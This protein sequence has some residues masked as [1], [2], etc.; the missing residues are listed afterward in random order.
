M[1][2]RLNIRR[3]QMPE[4]DKESATF[5]VDK[6][7][8]EQDWNH[9]VQKLTQARRRD[10]ERSFPYLFAEMKIIRPTD[11][12]HLQPRD[13]EWLETQAKQN[14][15]KNWE[16]YLQCAYAL[17]LLNP[18]KRLNLPRN[19]IPDFLYF[20]TDENMGDENLEIVHNTFRAKIAHPELEYI[21]LD[22]LLPD[23]KKELAA[24]F[25]DAGEDE[26]RSAARSAAEIR[27]LYPEAYPTV[28]EAR[29][30]DLRAALALYKSSDMYRHELTELAAAMTI[31]AA[32]DAR[33]TDQG[34]YILRHSEG[35]TQAE[36]RSQPDS[37]NI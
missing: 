23:A 11:T 34:L 5:D 12:R 14:I 22:D 13:V 37:L 30:K 7:I 31:L 3:M 35:Q 21:Y 24:A 1:N 18:N 19:K 33:I 16:R 28:S 10:G 9:M 2:E 32:E 20:L 26:V 27:A 29:W 25:K 17:K 4:Q 15:G 6:D 8:T 36:I